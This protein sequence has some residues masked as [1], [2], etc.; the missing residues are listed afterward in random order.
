MYCAK[1]KRE[2]PSL[3]TNYLNRLHIYRKLFD[4]YQFK[5]CLDTEIGFY[6]Y[7][8]CPLD[9]SSLGYQRRFIC[10]IQSQCFSS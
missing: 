8:V 3:H 6:Y 10:K 1:A 2:H 5:I 7:W 9:V 4:I